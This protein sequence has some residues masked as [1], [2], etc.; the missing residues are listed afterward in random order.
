MLEAFQLLYFLAGAQYI[1]GFANGYFN[2]KVLYHQQI[3][4]HSN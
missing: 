1:F 3:T 4:T 2:G